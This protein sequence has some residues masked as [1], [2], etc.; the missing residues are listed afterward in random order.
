MSKESKNADNGQGVEMVEVVLVKRTPAELKE[1]RELEAK[2][3]GCWG[4]ASTLSWTHRPD[5]CG[6]RTKALPRLDELD[7]WN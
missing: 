2:M 5:E 3:R 1:E 4:N 6:K 7:K